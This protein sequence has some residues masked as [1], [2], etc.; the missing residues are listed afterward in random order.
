MMKMRLI[1]R[2]RYLSELVSVIG[3]PDIKVIT[4]IRRCGKSKLLEALMSYLRTN[5]EDVNIIHVNYS[6]LEFEYLMEYHALNDY[7]ESNYKEGKM[8]VVCIDEVQ[9]C[10]SFEKTI[11][12][13]HSSEKYDIFITGSNAF[14]MSSDLA[15]LFTGRTIEVEVFPFSFAE[16]LTYYPSNNLQESFDSYLK[17]G[18]MAGSYVYSERKQKA[19]YLNDEV[20]KSLIVRDII[21]K[22][23]I[24]NNGALEKLIDFL[25]DNIGNVTS[26]RNM[27]NVL[28]LNNKT[29]VT[30]MDYLCNA[31]AFYNI[32]RYDLKGKKYL[33]SED[34]YYLA[35]HSFRYARLGSK[36]MDYGRMYEN[37]VA[38]ELLRRGYEIYVGILYKKEVDF[39]AMRQNE[40]LY[41]QV[42]DDITSES[43]FYREV[44]ALLSIKDAYPKLLIARTRH[45][46][47]DYQGIRVIDLADWLKNE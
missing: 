16:Y 6:S 37:M 3:S 43:T 35:D 26:I 30:Y 8:N 31:F 29:L 17:D 9:M 5:Y 41:I 36:N 45:E 19:K 46:E 18:G 2:L 38:I 12:S 21:A 28:G 7:V 33:A 20:F 39:V 15:T 4:G 47:Y 10:P 44:S 27:A 23:K 25:M 42:S 1:E 32:R 14:L 13:L 40:R 24:R 11:N 34:K 22:H